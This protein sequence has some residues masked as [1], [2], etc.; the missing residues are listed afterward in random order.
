M[1]IDV[2]TLF[3]EMFEGVLGSSMLGR[4]RAN[5]LLDTRVHNIRDYTDNKHKKTDDYPFGGGAGMVMMAQPI[6]DCMAAVQGEEKAHRILLTPR[7]KPLTTERAR[8]LSGEERLILLCGHYEGVDERV[9][10]LI[11]EEISIGDY[12]LTGGELP[13]MVLIDC[14]SRFIPGVLGSAESAEDESFSEGLLEYPQYTRPADFRGRLVP[15]VLLNGH[16]ANIL[17][18]RREQAILK[19]RANRPDLL[20]PELRAEKN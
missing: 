17:K 19:T 4:A 9:M 18:W 12:V 20:P 14:V 5:G 8:A 7:G 15:E 3:P 11:D 6:F 1:R 10:E 13:A 16:H 2:L